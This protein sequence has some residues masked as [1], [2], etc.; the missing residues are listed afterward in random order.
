MASPSTPAP[1]RAGRREWSALAVLVLVVMLLAVDGTVL[2]LAVPS[3]TADISPSATQLL[4]IGDIYS[5]VLAG[6]LITMGNVADRIGR[7]RLLL[8]GSATFGIA[9]AIAAFSPNPEILIATRALLGIAG[10]TLMPSTLSIVRAMFADAKQ[11]TTAIAIWSAGAMAGAAVGPLVGGVLLEHFWW[12]SVFLINLPIMALVLIAGPILIPESHGDTSQRVDLV[13]SVLSIVAIVPV[14]YAV[15]HWVGSGWDLSVPIFALA[16]VAFGAIFVRRQLRLTHPLLD[17]S[18]FRVPAFAGTVAA[19]GLAIFAFVGL[20]Y[21]FSQYLQLVRGYGPL[22][23]GSAELPTTLASMVVV[24]FVGALGARLGAGRA[25]ALGLAVGAVGL[26][27]MG[28]TTFRPSYLGL[29]IALVVVGLG[30]G[31]T[32]T[33]STDAVVSAVPEQRAGA[34]SAISE[35]AY[36]LGVA[37]GIAVLGSIHL[38]MYRSHLDLPSGTDPSDAATAEASLA[39]TVGTVT[40]PVVVDHARTAF[41]SAVQTTSY[42]AAAL[43]FVAAVVAWRVIPSPR[44]VTVVDHGAH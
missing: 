19:N 12:G 32:M 2:H 3:L 37:L 40:D 18:L 20:L 39:V 4:W 10:A 25:I 31:V 42:V 30:I 29:G 41:A 38:A 35:T 6:L 43:L 11:R 13:S 27:G 8:I 1:P 5:F 21:F 15:K 34:A 23:A 22:Q 36:E 33:L 14:V 9:S 26:V 24:V 17:I 16:G 7:K 44:N 28:L